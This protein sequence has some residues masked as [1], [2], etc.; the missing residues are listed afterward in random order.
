VAGHDGFACR[1]NPDR[2]RYPRAQMIEPKMI[3]P[4]RRGALGW[5][6][7]FAPEMSPYRSL[8][9]TIWITPHGCAIFYP[10]G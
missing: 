7:A 8:L 5:F 4:K 6:A 3:E 2:F 10:T 9:S 1:D